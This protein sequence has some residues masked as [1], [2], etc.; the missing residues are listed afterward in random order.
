MGVSGTLQEIE[1]VFKKTYVGSVHE[2]MAEDNMFLMKLEAYGMKETVS[3]KE[4]TFALQYSRS[5]GI[6]FRDTSTEVPL[7]PDAST[8]KHK[9]GSVKIKELYGRE[10]FTIMQ[11][12]S[13]KGAG[14]FVGTVVDKTEQMIRD[15]RDAY[16]I[17]L[18]TNQKGAITSITAAVAVGTPTV[19]EVGDKVRL[20]EG[21][22]VDICK[23]DGTVLVR[24]VMIKSYDDD[25]NKV[26]VDLTN[27]TKGTGDTAATTLYGAVLGT[28]ADAAIAANDI[29]VFEKSYNLSYNGLEEQI[30]ESGTL[31]GIDRSVH[32]FYTSSVR[33]NNNAVLTNKDIRLVKNSILRKSRK[34]NGYSLDCA[35]GN[36]DEISGFED[37]LDDSVTYDVMSGDQAP[38][39]VGG[40]SVLK[41]DNLDIIGDRYATAHT[42]FT[43]STPSFSLFQ[44][45]DTKFLDMGEGIFNRNYQKTQYEFTLYNY[46]NLV[47]RNLR[48][49]GAIKNVK[50]LSE[51]A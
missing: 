8:G 32:K 21:N 2:Q 36:Y 27:A 30:L 28:G 50:G 41:H 7:L 18:Y 3:G 14:A 35:L 43:I 13:S 49:N 44:I 17:S 25:N 37:T 9:Q 23:P 6:G 16:G 33:D 47:N 29:V 38:N 19:I 46:Q 4:P 15:F 11:V 31:H 5:G 20:Q 39:L 26:T 10:E 48:S 24:K 22:V 45:A 1:D 12:E 40:Y 34:E 42:L 51:L